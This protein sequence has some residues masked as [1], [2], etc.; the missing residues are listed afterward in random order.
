MEPGTWIRGAQGAQGAPGSGVMGTRGFSWG[1]W[2][3]TSGVWGSLLPCRRLPRAP[4]RCHPAPRRGNGNFG[5]IPHGSHPR[6][7][8]FDSRPSPVIMWLPGKEGS[9]RNRLLCLAPLQ[10][11]FLLGGTKVRA[12]WEALRDGSP[13][14]APGRGARSRAGCP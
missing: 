13:A 8:G 14:H 3:H 2:V 5:L 4:P 6:V 9:R 11:V 12:G 10:E 7:P 1:S